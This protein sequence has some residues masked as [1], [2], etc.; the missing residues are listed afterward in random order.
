MR[1]KRLEI[2]PYVLIEAGPNLPDPS[3]ARR[4]AFPLLTV[5][6]RPWVFAGI[7]LA[8]IGA[9]VLTRGISY[10]SHR[11][12]VKVGRFEASVQEQR[13]VPRWVGGVAIVGGVLMIGAGIRGRKA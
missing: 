8:A 1:D 5:H 9:F 11:S 3:P 4:W 6:M 2:G 7:V 12:A 10:P 13:A